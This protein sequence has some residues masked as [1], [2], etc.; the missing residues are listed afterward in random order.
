MDL[1]RRCLL[2]HEPPDGGVAEN[3]LQLATGLREHGWD[4]YVAGPR[5]SAIADRL[6]EAGVPVA[7][8]PFRSGFGSPVADAN[9]L[10][11]LTSLLRHNDFDLVHLHSAKA[12]VLGR[13]AAKATATPVVYSPHSFPFVGPWGWQ[14]RTVS[15]G[16]E[17]AL[18]GFT[19]ELVC[20]CEYERRLALA[21]NLVAPEHAH[22]VYNG[23]ASLPE[24]L[25]ADAEIRAFAGDSPI[26]GCVTVLRPQK[27]VETF[28]DAIPLVLERVGN[29]KFVVAGDGPDRD[30]LVGRAAALG[31][32]DAVGF[33]G[34]RPPGTGQMAALDVFVLPSAWEAFPIAL[35]EAMACGVPQV[36]TD[37]GG[38]GEAV[39]DGT[40]GLLCPPGDPQ[41]LAAAITNLLT[42]GSLRNRMAAA[43]RRRH[44][45]LFTVDRMVAS[46][47][48]V[49]DRVLA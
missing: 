7:R 23:S 36:A 16:M 49:Y 35:L 20:V 27:S 19:G 47:A 2:V 38:V 17:R 41:Q 34:F 10:R 5:E 11:K 45:Q 25:E 40:T 24:D 28:I 9:A 6:R 26:A 22:L 3:V 39:A 1:L 46:T 32:S 42:N 43:S 21:H 48:A 44:S 33:F 37:V 12:G 18:R 4:P 13:L 14:R 30:S 15:T 8:L 29:A 31:I